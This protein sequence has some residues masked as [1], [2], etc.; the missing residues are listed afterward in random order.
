M[1]KVLYNEL[2]GPEGVTLRLEAAGH[3]GYAPAGQDTMG[4]T[5]LAEMPSAAAD[6]DTE[7]AT[8]TAADL[9]TVC[10]QFAAMSQMPGFDRSMLQK[11]LD[12]AMSQLDSTL[13][14]NLKSQ[15]LLLVQLEYEA[16][17]VA[18]DVQ[19]VIFNSNEFAEERYIDDKLMLCITQHP[20]VLERP[21]HWEGGAKQSFDQGMYKADLLL[22]VKQKDY[23]PMPK[24]GKQITLDKKRDYK[25]KSCSLKAG[26][27]RMELE[28]VR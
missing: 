25:I 3:A 4:M 15:S 9:D 17:G 23:G 14:E 27:Y 20:G 2:D 8:P 21:A 5:G 13:L 28:R 7:T 1:I 10:S 19:N 16:Q 24:N 18:Q 11:Q 22:F 6:T 12:G 26:V